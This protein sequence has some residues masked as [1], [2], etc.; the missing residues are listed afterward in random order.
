[1]PVSHLTLNN[2]KSYSGVQTIGPF[3]DFTC[4]IGPNG[5]GEY[6][7]PPPKPLFRI[8]RPPD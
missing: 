3:K 5:A 2:F 7:S 8:S 6:P 4:V 1:M